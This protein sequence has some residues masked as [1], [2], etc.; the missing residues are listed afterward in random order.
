MV[1]SFKEMGRKAETLI[2]QGKEADQKVQH[3]QARVVS[4]NSRVAAARKQLADASEVDEEGK[5]IG[6][7]DHAQTQLRMAE[8]QLAAS[9]RALSAARSDFERVRQHKNDHVREIERYNRIERSNLQKLSQLRSGTFGENS[10]ELTEG[11]IQRLNEAEDARVDLLRSMG[12]DAVAD[13]ITFSSGR[14][15]DSGWRG[16]GSATLDTTRQVQSHRGTDSEGLLSNS[17]IAAPV[18]GDL[19]ASVNMDERTKELESSPGSEVSDR[20]VGQAEWITSI[21]QGLDDEIFFEGVG[22]KESY[23]RLVNEIVKNNLLSTEQK[24]ADLNMIKNQLAVLSKNYSGRIEAEAIKEHIKSLNLSP[25]EKRQMGERYI[26]NILEVCRE[27]LLDR[28]VVSIS[29]IDAT[30]SELRKHYLSELEKDLWEQPNGLYSDPDYDELMDRIRRRRPKIADIL[31]GTDMSFEQADSGHVNPCFFKEIAYQMNC[32][33]CVVVFEARLRGYNVEVLPNKKGSVLEFLSYDPRM[34]WIDPKTGKHPEYIY[35]NMRRTPEAYLDFVKEIVKPGNRYT[36]QFHWNVRDSYAHIVNI[37]RTSKGLLRI[38][39]NQ[40]H[41]ECEVP[42]E[43]IGDDEVLCYLSR[44][45][46]ENI[47]FWGKRTPCVPKLLRIDNMD[48]DFS[49]VNYIMKGAAN[50]ERSGKGFR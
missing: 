31:P 29:A 13:H 6:D 8:N 34:A 10:V 37:D 46:Y 38:K 49:I 42:N 40:L 4:S 26:D 12:I 22:L 48:F 32:Q 9:E 28:G 23:S 44:F 27:N 20:D 14:G 41:P 17:G 33:S 7:V 1:K 18:G 19:T 35:D 15:M 36:I 25:E 47:S 2:E 16:G 24:I 5:P 39:D 3:C 43:Y 21:S 50:D 45:K 11:M 30:M